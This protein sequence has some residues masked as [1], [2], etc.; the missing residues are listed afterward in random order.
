MGSTEGVAD[1]VGF[2]DVHV[3]SHISFAALH[4][5]GVG[6]WHGK[7]HVGMYSSGLKE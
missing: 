7:H 1:C 3:F 5:T 6:S 2:V 4:G